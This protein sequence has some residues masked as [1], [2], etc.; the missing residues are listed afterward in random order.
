M[1]A[2]ILAAGYATRLYPLTKDRPKPLLDVKGKP[3]IEH[4]IDKIQE[5]DEIDEIFVITNNKFF[6][7][8]LAW[9]RRFKSRVKI[10]IVNDQ[11]DSN[12]DRLGSLGDIKYVI[13]NK[14]VKEDLMIVAGDNLFEFALKPMVKIYKEKQKPVVA[15]YNVKKIELAR[16]YG[17]VSI[18]EN[19]KIINFEEKPPEPKSTL[20]STGIYIYPQAIIKKLLLF[21]KTHDSDKIGSF[22]EWLYKEEDIYCYVTEKRWY[23]IGSLES[24]EE[25][26][27]EYKTKEEI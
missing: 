27:A 14:N 4:I 1:K 8:F 5:I 21:V 3:I 7:N 26:E 13:E 20:S 22:L 6:K 9:E 15:L 25:A 16:L 11:T 23:D 17:I 12:E 18:D 24:L 19:S 2:L 10:T